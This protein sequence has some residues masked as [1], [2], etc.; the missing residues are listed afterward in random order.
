MCRRNIASAPSV[1]IYILFI[2]ISSQD[3]RNAHLCVTFV[4]R[5][6]KV[7]QNKHST[8]LYIQYI[9]HTHIYISTYIYIRHVSSFGC[10]SSDLPSAARVLY[11]N[12]SRIYRQDTRDGTRCV[13]RILCDTKTKLS[14]PNRLF[15]LLTRVQR[16]STRSLRKYYIILHTHTMD[17][18]RF[19]EI[20]IPRVR[21]LIQSFGHLFYSSNNED[22]I[23]IYIQLY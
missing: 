16:R 14:R 19:V 10:L 20:I 7:M 15:A 4:G 3:L 12:G 2:F 6:N 23:T 21:G 22:N 1:Y 18:I 8:I 11:E 17:S 5:T 9:I 13:Q